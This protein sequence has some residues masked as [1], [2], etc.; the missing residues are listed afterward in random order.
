MQE[1]KSSDETSTLPEQ[2]VP[3][4]IDDGLAAR[5]KVS[6]MAESRATSPA[7]AAGEVE[8]SR[9]AARVVKVTATGFANPLMPVTRSL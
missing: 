1:A 4:V 2:P 5:E 3:E 6:E 7:P 9:M 8:E